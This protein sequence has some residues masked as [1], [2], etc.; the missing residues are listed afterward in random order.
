MLIHL[1]LSDKATTY[2]LGNAL[3]GI[4]VATLHIGARN[5]CFCRSMNG[6]GRR[7][8]RTVE[9]GDGS[10]VAHHKVLKAPFVSQDGLKQT[11]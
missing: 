7:L 3:V 5:S 8:M 6:I 9:V 1:S 2:C 11:L 10:A 4:A